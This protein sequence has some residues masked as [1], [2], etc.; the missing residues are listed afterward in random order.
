[1]N[2][3]IKLNRIEYMLSLS[4]W[5]DNFAITN[6]SFFQGVFESFWEHF[7]DWW[8]NGNDDYLIITSTDNY[9]RILVEN[10]NI[11]EGQ[12]MVRK[13]FTKRRAKYST[14]K[15]DS[16]FKYHEQGKI[17]LLN[18]A[19]VSFKFALCKKDAKTLTRII[20]DRLTRRSM[21]QEFERVIRYSTENN[22]A[23]L[24]KRNRLKEIDKILEDG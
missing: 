13:E 23:Y 22:N 16:R 1:M 2:K 12:V 4:K 21:T 14:C 11:P 20:T 8:F 17:I 7:E 18:I 10:Y 15:K 9:R 6:V 24:K 19:D 3:K 5:K